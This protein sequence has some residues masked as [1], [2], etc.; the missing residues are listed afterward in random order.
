MNIRYYINPRT[1]KQIHTPTMVQ[2]GGGDWVDGTHP[3]SFWYVAVF[4]NDILPLVESLSSSLQ[5]EVYFMGG[6]AAEGL[7]RHQQWLPSWLQSWI[8]PRIRNQ[9]KIVRNG[10]FFVLQMK[11]NTQLSTLYDFGHKI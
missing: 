9:V 10:D 4:C 11:N 7:W 6:G 1:Y 5:D 8:L 3:Q 2:G